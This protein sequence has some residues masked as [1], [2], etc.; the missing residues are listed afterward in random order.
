MKV[1]YSFSVPETIISSDSGFK[2]EPGMDFHFCRPFA[3]DRITAR[4]IILENM[5]FLLGE[6]L[7]VFRRVAAGPN[8]G[9]GYRLKGLTK[10]D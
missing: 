6:L 4:K 8:G 9:R 7:P 3:L 5:A 1:S 2:Q 10:D